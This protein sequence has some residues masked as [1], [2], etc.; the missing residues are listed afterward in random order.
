M[1]MTTMAERSIAYIN[2]K[3]VHDK[4][5]IN[6]YDNDDHDIDDHNEGNH[7]KDNDN[8]DNINSKHNDNKEDH[9]R[10]NHNKED[11]NPFIFLKSQDFKVCQNHLFLLGLIK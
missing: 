4:A 11:P 5:D 8:K 1:K 9:S 6:Y 7:E 2:Y 3:K 10:E